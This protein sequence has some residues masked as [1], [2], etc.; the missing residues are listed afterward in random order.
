MLLF[1]VSQV[2]YEKDARRERALAGQQ[3]LDK[4]RAA[5]IKAKK[6]ARPK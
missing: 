4:L 5:N 2:I 3:E 1:C 6:A